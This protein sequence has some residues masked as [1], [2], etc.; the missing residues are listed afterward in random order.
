MV[1]KSGAWIIIISLVLG[2]WMPIGEAAAAENYYGTPAINAL[3]TN[4][5]FNDISQHWA[6][7]SI[8][9]MAALGVIRDSGDAYRPEALA[10]KEDTLGA[11]M[12]LGELEGMAQ[13]TWVAPEEEAGFQN[14]WGANYVAWAQGKGIITAEERATLNWKNPATREELAYWM[15]RILNF[16]PVYGREQQAVL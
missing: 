3:Y 14:L 15:A 2:M 9:R 5:S 13:Q 16:P 10:S 6:R 7:A 11:L 1:R 4:A 8:Y 12:R